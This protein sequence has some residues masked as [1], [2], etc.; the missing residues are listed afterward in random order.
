MPS[1]FTTPHASERADGTRRM[2]AR[3]LPGKLTPLL[4][5]HTART[6]VD[7]GPIS[8]RNTSGGRVRFGRAAAH[9]PT[10]SSVEGLARPHYFMK[11]TKSDSHG[12]WRGFTLSLIGGVMH[13]DRYEVQFT[14]DLDEVNA[15]RPTRGGVLRRR[16]FRQTIGDGSGVHA[17]DWFWMR[18]NRQDRRPSWRAPLYYDTGFQHLGARAGNYAL[19]RGA[20]FETT[21]W[22]FHGQVKRRRRASA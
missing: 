15:Y 12:I 9:L 18:E 10:A 5:S 2:V 16:G 7:Q 20:C 4:P 17:R 1:N 19:H 6:Y 11:T 13:V 8:Y 21:T 3:V 14:D 22:E